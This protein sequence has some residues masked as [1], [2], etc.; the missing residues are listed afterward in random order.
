MGKPRRTPIPQDLL[1]AI[2]TEIRF[3]FNIAEKLADGQNLFAGLPRALQERFRF[4]Q[5]VV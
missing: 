1:Q 2:L 3:G 5:I 4:N